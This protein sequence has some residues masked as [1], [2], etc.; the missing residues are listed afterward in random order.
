MLPLSDKKC[1]SPANNGTTDGSRYHTRTWPLDAH[2]SIMCSFTMDNRNLSFLYG[3][4]PAFENESSARRYRKCTS[5]RDSIT[6][7]MSSKATCTAGGRKIDS[8]TPSQRMAKPQVN[9]IN[10]SSIPITK[11]PSRLPSTSVMRSRRVL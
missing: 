1:C 8:K 4:F 10:F 11:C 9:R 7:C 6:T 2:S 5:I 3:H